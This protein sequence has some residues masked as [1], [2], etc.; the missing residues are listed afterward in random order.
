M[1][2]AEEYAAIEGVTRV[3]VGVSIAHDEV[4]YGLRRRERLGGAG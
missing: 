4:I 3:A 2:G 1:P